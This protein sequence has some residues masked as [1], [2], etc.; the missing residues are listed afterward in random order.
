MIACIAFLWAPALLSLES[1]QAGPAS[2]PVVLESILEKLVV[3][4]QYLRASIAN[5][6]CTTVESPSGLVTRRIGVV[7]RD[8]GR[9]AYY[10]S[11]QS[12]NGQQFIHRG[13]WD[14]INAWVYRS[15]ANN[16]RAPAFELLDVRAKVTKLDYPHPSASAF[17]QPDYFGSQLLGTDWLTVLRNSVR[18]LSLSRELVEGQEC[19]TL[20][21]DVYSVNADAARFSFPVK[22]SFEVESALAIKSAILRD[23]SDQSALAH[24]TSGGLEICGRRFES[25]VEWTVTSTERLGEQVLVPSTGMT[26]S[27]SGPHSLPVEV[28][29]QYLPTQSRDEQLQLLLDPTFPP[30]TLIMDLSGSRQMY[31]G[32]DGLLRDYR[33]SMFLGLLEHAGLVDMID[34]EGGSLD[35][36]RASCGINCTFLALR[37]LGHKL[38]QSDCV[39]L[40]SL[41]RQNILA[42]SSF[43]D[44][45][46][47][48]GQLHEPVVP[49]F[50]SPEALSGKWVVA[51][52]HVKGGMTS[53]PDHFVVLT[54]SNQGIQVLDPPRTPRIISLS[55]ARDTYGQQAL[56]FGIGENSGRLQ[57]R[58]TQWA[59]LAC[60][61]VS[62]GLCL[63]L[64]RRGMKSRAH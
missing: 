38:R 6:E 33:D 4:G 11:I 20:L 45:A 13:I 54:N 1:I 57:W 26:R 56:L 53:R 59:I 58:D 64:V 9:R 23:T 63:L 12:G 10:E 52:A 35:L 55:E 34:Y 19:D 40:F 14:S 27:Q 5:Y 43:E 30:K 25:L 22:V 21:V 15:E 62:T 17:Y 60:V 28:S 48:A 46:N 51:I 39:Q 24:S 50:G 31:V 16:S 29:M 2:V 7:G 36:G 32:S 44:I 18:I 49:I 41:D 37:A 61:M 47:A 3:R 42:D 8:G